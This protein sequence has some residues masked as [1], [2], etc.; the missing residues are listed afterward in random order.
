MGLSTPV[1]ESASK[2]LCYK[3]SHNCRIVSLLCNCDCV[4]VEIEH[5]LKTTIFKNFSFNNNRFLFEITTKLRNRSIFNNCVNDLGL[6]NCHQSKSF[7]IQSSVQSWPC[8][9]LPRPILSRDVAHTL[10]SL[11]IDYC[12]L[13]V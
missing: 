13:H 12:L 6:I 7:I 4:I 1:F 3:Q 9:L 2:L 5:Q 10:P 8:D 11:P